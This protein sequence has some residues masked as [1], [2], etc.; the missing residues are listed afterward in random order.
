MR[1]STNTTSL[2]STQ[3]RTSTGTLFY[4]GTTQNTDIVEL[5]IDG[6]SGRRIVPDRDSTIYMVV[7]AVRRLNTGS[8]RVRLFHAVFSLDSSGALVSTDLDG[9][10]VGVQNT[11]YFTTNTDS[12][13][14]APNSSG[15]VVQSMTANGVLFDFVPASGNTPSY[16]RCRVSGANLFTNYWGIR[17]NYVEVS[18]VMN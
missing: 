14:A 5:F 9:T 17:V 13:T 12:D 11:A 16:V 3:P 7:T 1:F 8:T 10:T 6:A 2:T 4:R 18:N 15:L